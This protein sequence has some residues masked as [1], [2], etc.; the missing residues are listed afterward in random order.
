MSKLAGLSNTHGSII[1]LKSLDNDDQGEIGGDR[2]KVKLAECNCKLKINS[3]LTSST[4]H[5]C[6]SRR[7][8]GQ[9]YF[10]G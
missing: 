6:E 4:V 10:F 2:S 1:K 3:T 7:S 5:V 9:R 8:L